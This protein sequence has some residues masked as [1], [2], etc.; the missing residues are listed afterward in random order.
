VLSCVCASLCGIE[1]VVCAAV[2]VVADGDSGVSGGDNCGSSF[3]PDW[4]G[5]SAYVTSASASGISSYH[6]D[7][8]AVSVKTGFAFTTGGG[9]STFFAQPSYQAA[10]VKGY[11]S[12][13]QRQNALPPTS[14]FNVKGRAYPD[15]ST[16]GSG[17]L[18]FYNDQGWL[19]PFPGGGQCCRLVFV[20]AFACD[21]FACVVLRLLVLVFSLFSHDQ[22]APDLTAGTSFSAPLMAGMFAMLNAVRL[23]AGRPVLG[24]AN[25][26]L[27][28][29]AAQHPEAFYD[30]TIG[31]TPS[32]EAAHF[33]ACCAL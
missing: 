21:R 25:P 19:N 32:F 17:L 20:F 15:V 16:L 30:I 14:Y 12:A 8:V 31:L 5:S 28:Q 2:Q 13:A 29:T 3:N 4:P 11:L 9:F 24:F 18:T 26:W 7:C 23:N 33:D 1:A 6:A 22:C 10:A 27:Y